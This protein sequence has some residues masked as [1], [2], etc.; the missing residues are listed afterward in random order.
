MRTFVGH[1][2]GSSRGPRH[3]RI[4]RPTQDPTQ[5]NS[6]ASTSIFENCLPTPLGHAKGQRADIFA[7]MPE[8][9]IVAPCFNEEETLPEFV[10]R[11]KKAL[12]GLDYEIVLVN[13][14]S[15]DST[16]QL[17]R[18]MHLD[19]VRVRPIHLSRNFGHQAAVTAGLDQAR[20]DAIVTIDADLQDP[21][22][23]ILQL[24]EAWRNGAEVVHAQREERPGEP[25]LRMLAIRLFYWLLIKFS[26]LRDY[27]GNSADFRL[28]SRKALDAMAQLPERN[29][30]VRGLIAWIGFEQ[31]VVRYPRHER[32]SGESKYVLR[33]R[34]QLALDGLLSFSVIPLR[35][36]SLLG[37]AISALAFLAIPLVAV[38]KIVG[39][40]EVTGTAS[41]HILVLLMA[42]VQLFFLGVIGEYVGRTYDESKRRPIYIIDDDR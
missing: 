30:F 19:D 26:V 16:R 24:V 5:L 25:P 4:S 8:L 34:V 20:G 13:D 3:R 35:L 40:Y 17:M 41:V 32:F 27:P 33:K 7:A 28:M 11:L 18:E 39:L 1:K 22:E 38:L 12:E 42:G 37:I 23:V 10:R 29:R 31:T 36:A 15:T 6:L 14:G 9:S 2:R 21:P